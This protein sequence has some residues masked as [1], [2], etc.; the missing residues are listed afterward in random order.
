[1][2]EA[3]RGP[4]SL[5]A[6]FVTCFGFVLFVV[7]VISNVDFLGTRNNDQER[8]GQISDVFDERLIASL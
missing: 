1:M 7:S 8:T 4:S 5:A 6:A 2:V 3:R